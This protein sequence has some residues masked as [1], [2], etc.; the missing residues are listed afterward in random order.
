MTDIYADNSWMPHRISPTSKRGMVAAKM[1]QAAR[2]GA[3][4]IARGGNA[5]D[6]AVATA[7][8]V[9]V[10]EPWM[11]GIGG[12]GYLVAWLAK[13]QRAITI[14]FAMQAP[15]GATE[16]MYPMSDEVSADAGF[17]GWPTTKGNRHVMGPHSI[18]VPGTV[19]GLSLAL[20]EYGTIS[21][22]DAMAPG[23]ALAEDGFP[24]TWHTTQLLAKSLV[25]IRAYPDTAR[26]F[27]NAN[28]D[29]PF[30]S[31]QPTPA[32]IRQPE[33]AQT[34]RLIAAGGPD[35]FYRGEIA[36]KIAAHLEAEGTVF[37]R[38]DMANYEA[39][40][41]EPNIAEYHD[42]TVYTTTGGSGG[43]SLTQALMALN[44]LD[45]GTVDGRTPEQWHGMAHCFRQAF[46]DRFTYLADPNFVHVPIA[47]MVSPEYA[48]VTTAALGENA[49]TPTPGSREVLGV[50]HQLQASVPE[51]MKDGS[52]THLSVMD[53]EG[54]AV[55]ITQT[56]LSL[57]G[58]FVT[59]PGTG[60]L[61][62]NGMMWFDPEP[63]RPNSIAGG[64]R[65]LS[66][67]APAVIVRDGT[68]I[69]SLG[70]SGG[71]KI[72]NCNA[73]L[74]M[75][76]VDGDMSA[77]TA[78]DAPRIDCSTRE[79]LVSTRLDSDTRTA[80]ED[81]GYSLGLRHEALLTG[82]F[83]SPTAIRRSADGT[84]DGGADPWYMPATVAA[85]ED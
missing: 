60:I 47:A 56:L 73:Q 77:Q 41:V 43:T 23:I 38:D 57:F 82:D 53:G 32:W 58:S 66:N 55:S 9:G 85:V 4:I 6:A 29:A 12:G 64:K 59:I 80:L 44:L 2:I 24:V 79:V 19:A 18:A 81:K 74:I 83:S 21:L 61:M 51:Y 31:E 20:R 7:F 54:N 30:T 13:E 50:Q 16:T 69:A 52:T 37:S 68:A 62:N 48:R 33:L 28:G 70:A 27:L 45:S 42:H 36:D 22:A 26:T 72:M 5:I 3:D 40:I 25:A 34:L 11:N 75:N 71:R 76:L 35:A 17:F 39:H 46:A 10:C 67:M 15:A 78:I 8:A 65:P 14:D 49:T 63:G 1:P 84:L